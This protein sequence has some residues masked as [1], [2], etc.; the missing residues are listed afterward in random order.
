MTELMVKMQGRIAY[1]LHLSEYKS[2]YIHITQNQGLIHT[3][4]SSISPV[5]VSSSPTSGRIPLR[6]TVFIRKKASTGNKTYSIHLL[7]D[8]FRRCFVPN[9][10]LVDNENRR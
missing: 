5:V 6:P 8:H 9:K 4:N 3:N 10:W 7:N 1:A 2:C